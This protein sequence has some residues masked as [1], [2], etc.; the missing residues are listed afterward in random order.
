LETFGRHLLSD[1]PLLANDVTTNRNYPQRFDIKIVENLFTGIEPP[2]RFS[3][4]VGLADISG[5]RRHFTA[6]PVSAYTRT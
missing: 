4:V 6:V 1:I 2:F 5:T 3:V